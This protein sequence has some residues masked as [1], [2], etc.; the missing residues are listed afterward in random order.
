MK[1]VTAVQ[2]A[3]NIIGEIYP[4]STMWPNVAFSGFPQM[5]T[6]TSSLSG[7]VG[8]MFTP[9][10][11]PDQVAEFEAFAYD[12]YSKNPDLYAPDVA[13]SS[14]GRGIF[15]YNLSSNA[16]D[17]RYHDTEGITPW[18]SANTFLAPILQF[19]GPAYTRTEVN[20][21]AMLNMRTAEETCSDGQDRGMACMQMRQFHNESCSVVSGLQK[22]NPVFNTNPHSF[23]IQPIISSFPETRVVGYVTGSLLFNNLLKE[24]TPVETNGIDYVIASGDLILSFKIIHGLSLIHI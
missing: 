21:I 7:S 5:A 19:D 10:V 13:T 15:S 18:P 4:N 11:Y 1:T 6:L 9:V 8:M 20:T 23:V 2:N 24:K 22:M 14:F 17:R 12:F 3:V 16:P